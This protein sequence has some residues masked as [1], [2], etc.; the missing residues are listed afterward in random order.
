MLH[1]LLLLYTHVLRA[2]FKCFMFQVFCFHVF[3]VFQTYVAK[4][5]LDVAYVVIAID[6]C[7]KSIF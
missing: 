6:A 2:Y 7:F 4:V 5:D 1:I 3:R